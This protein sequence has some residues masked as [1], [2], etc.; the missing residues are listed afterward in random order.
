[1]C[2][3]KLSAGKQLFV[4]GSLFIKVLTYLAEGLAEEG[5][6]RALPP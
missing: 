6:S 2:A 1:M 5:Y 4:L 3:T